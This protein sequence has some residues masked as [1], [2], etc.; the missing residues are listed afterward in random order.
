MLPSKSV[1]INITLIYLITFLLNTFHYITTKMYR[2]YR[3]VV[4]WLPQCGTVATAI[5]YCGYQGLVVMPNDS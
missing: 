1:S 5:W 2:D 4:S 3:Y